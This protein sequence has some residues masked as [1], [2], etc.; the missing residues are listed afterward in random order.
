[1][2][3]KSVLRFLPIFLTLVFTASAAFAQSAPAI[4]FT[5][6][7]SGPNTGGENN[8]GTILT[9]Y[10]KNF[11]ATQGTS[12]VTVGGGAVAAYKVWDGHGVSQPGPGQYETISVAIGSA[13]STGQVVVHVNGQS[14][15]CADQINNCQFTVRSGSIYCVSTS[16][17]D[18]N[19]GAF[20]SSCWATITK[21]AHTLTS[22]S[23]AYAEN[24]VTTSGQDN[25]S[26]NVV[27]SSSCTTAA[28]CA[29]VAYPGATVTVGG[30]SDQ[31]RGFY[32]GYEPSNN[33][34]IAGMTIKARFEGIE[35]N[36]NNGARLV[37]NNISCPNGSGQDACIH[38]EGGAQNI[39]FYGNYVNTTGTNCGSDCKEYHAFYMSTN[40]VHVWVGW[41][42][43]TPNPNKTA[44]AGCRAIQF[45]STGGSDQYDVHVFDNYIHDAICDGI[46]F[47]TVNP[48]NGTVEAYNNVVA[49][50]GTGPD[51]NGAAANYT[52][53][54][55]GSS[56][57]PS[58][59]VQIYNN[60][61]YDCGGRGTS[62]G[63]AGGFS[64]FITC[65]LQ[66]NIVYELAGESYL[67]RSTS[68]C[69]TSDIKGSN[70][71]WFGLSG[72]PSLT[73]NITSN[74][75][76]ASTSTPN[77]QLTSGSPAIGAGVNLGLATDILGVVRGSSVDIGA[78]QFAVGT[79]VQR[80]NPPTNVTVVVQ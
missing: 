18:S 40:T 14:S 54:N 28:P 8:N 39:F 48:N 66:N 69:C 73:A 71:I 20:P 16:G 50:V 31:N 76:F 37:G 60:T 58:T 75:N 33:W 41:N 78:Y 27:V 68:N 52:C 64:C 38:G 59:A 43:V 57:T 11:G 53:V 3:R 35:N 55:A 6:L 51:P 19:S 74:P 70:N 7:T 5:D 47:A 36:G 42:E 25:F 61:F 46:N 79:V 10:G 62:E 56:G 29:V 13:A 30:A 9:I 34:V 26:S 4:F 12:T 24:G 72:A 21:V 67:S 63:D 22:G 44:A 17:S 2:S 80:P 32:L 77:F 23:I 49:H 45:Y 1:M 65:N 15:T